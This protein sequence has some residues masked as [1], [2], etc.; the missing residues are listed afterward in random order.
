MLM[1][2]LANSSVQA[3]PTVNTISG[4]YPLSPY[5]GN[6]NGDTLHTALYHTPVGLA[7]DLSGR[8]LFV[9]DR[10]N[11]LVKLIDFGLGV[12]ADYGTSSYWITYANGLEN[13]NLFNKP[14]GVVVDQEYNVFV[15]CRAQGTNG[16]LMQLDIGGNLIATNMTKVGNANAIAEDLN[17]NLYVTASNNVYKVSITAGTSSLLT[18]IPAPGALLFGITVKH[19]GLLAVCD[20]GRN[21]ILLINPNTGV[22][23]TNAGFHGQGDFIDAEDTAS[24][25]QAAFFQ[26]A[27]I[28]ETGDGTMIVCDNGNNRVKAVLSNGTVTN[29]Y[30]VSTNDWTKNYFPGWSDG[31]VLLPD[32]LTPNV[33]SRAPNGVTFG[34]DGTVYVT[35]DYYHIIRKVTGT[36]LALPPPPPQPPPAAPGDLIVISTNYGQ[37]TLRW[38]GSSGATNYIVKRSTS[39]GGPYTIVGNVTD[40]GAQTYSFTDNTVGNGV[41]YFYVVSASNVNGESPNSAEVSVKTPIPPPPPPR[42]GWFDYEGNDQT[43]FFTVLHPV[44]LSVFNNDQMLAIDPGTNGVSTYYIAGPNPLAGTPSHT[45]GT[46]PPF[47]ADGKNFAQPLNLT[48]VPDLIVEAIN[49]DGINQSSAVTTAEFIFQVANPAINGNNGAQFTISE[50]TQNAT[51]WYTLDGSDPTNA[52]P[53]IG[54]ILA[55]TNNDPVNL[56]LNVTSN[57]LFK[58]RAFRNG[59]YPSGIAV[60]TF[61]TASFTPNTI[62]FGFASG[63]AS[64][65]FIASAGQSFYAPVTLLMISNSPLYSLQF[66]L[67]VTNAG[68]N[69]GP[70]VTPGAYGFNSFLE[71]P[72]PNSS[73]LVYEDIPPLIFYPYFVMNPPPPNQI[74]SFDGP[75]GTTNF[76]NTLTTNLSQ[77]L[78]SIGWLERLGQKN[79][80]DTTAQS[81]ITYSQ[82]HDVQYPNAANPGSIEVGGFSFQVPLTATNGQ[83]YRIA[84][85]SPSAT[86]DG[87]GAPGSDVFISAPNNSNY[88]GGSPINSTKYVTVGQRKYIVGSVYPFRWFNA[89]DFGSS[90][91]VSAD[92]AQVFQAAI[93]NLDTPPASSDFY[94]AMDS[95]GSYLAYLDGDTGY[96]T[97]D[98]TQV[99][100]A[101][102]LFDGN[103]TTINNLAYGDGV[104][105][106][107][108]VYVTFR[109][110]L[111]TNDL[112]W[113][114]RY[115]TNG[116]R[117]ATTIVPG[118]SP[119]IAKIATSKQSPTVQPKLQSSTVTPLVNFTAGDVIGSSGKT[120]QIPI[121]ATVLGSYPLRVL[122]LSLTVTPL[123]GSPALTTQVSFNQTS[124][125]LGSPYLVNSDANGNLAMTWLN[126]TNAGLTGT[127]T[128]GN[129]LVTIPATATTNAA[130]AIHF[131]HASASPNGLVSF[132]NTKLTGVLTTSTRTNSSYGDGIPDSWRLRWFGTIN[133]ILS[134]SNACPSGDG[135]DN[136][137]KYVAGVDPN[138]S[139]DFPAVNRKSPAPSGYNSA[140]HWPTVNGKKY[141]IERASLLFNGKWSMLSTNT[142]TGEDME[143]DDSN[144]NT[145]RFYRVLIQP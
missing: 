6:A 93:Y 133:N 67:S 22:V 48:T 20:R 29:L 145:V 35:E 34:Y 134:V 23:T 118:T 102:P 131:D 5:Y 142:G 61:S 95:C 71:E 116:V 120:F 11:N 1:L 124:P 68:P 121:T 84:I 74:V 52:P 32:N 101:N 54:P 9:A 47:Y 79:L 14:V 60:Q 115:W 59:Y 94:D 30:G 128:I 75:N 126:S 58:V 90:S 111:D 51:Y 97:N 27:G 125:T 104:L 138:A 112:T 106:V 63:E 65:D 66:N 36:G 50:V 80:F 41:T 127:F 140:I 31:Q 108:D 96:Y 123:D 78:L 39:S 82:A 10:D 89:G 132:P 119:N 21:G 17:T 144:T 143:Y 130:Y 19:N 141:V 72:I 7:V 45:N 129:L 55:D 8:Y 25:N 38:D 37:V 81:L 62:S 26:P 122:M 137:S 57:I 56:S 98:T 109:R 3:L 76:V 64:S 103:D 99:G 77:N 4:G 85:G 110:S 18:H 16:Y 12:T 33:Q 88:Y 100:H 73:P 53:S 69:P 139:G 107:C 13:T 24:S 28:A 70:P 43:G 2:L 105:D 135:V 49:V 15:L 136:W 42:I 114:S 87:I 91:L 83:T 113:F 117:V 86:D 44:T 92:V 46:T 40:T